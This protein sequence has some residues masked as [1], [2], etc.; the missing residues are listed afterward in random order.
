MVD[1]KNF[2]CE[3]CEKIKIRFAGPQCRKAQFAHIAYHIEWCLPVFPGKEAAVPISKLSKKST[4]IRGASVRWMSVLILLL[5]G[6][7]AAGRVGAEEKMPPLSGACEI[8]YPPFS[9][10]DEDGR[11]T[12]FSV[13]LLNAALAAMNR[14]ATYRTGPW[15]RVRG[16]LE[17]GE[18]EVLPLVGRTPEREELFDFTVPYMTMHGAIVVRDDV[19]GI[20]RLEDLR[21]RRVAVMKGDN[22]EE[23][24]RRE[25]RGIEIHTTPTFTEALQG[26]SRGEYDAVVVLRLVGLLLIREAGL[27][28]LRIIDRP[29]PDFRQ[30]FCFAV[31]DGDRKNLALLNEGLAIVMAD[32]TYRHLH[33][34]WFADLELPAN[35]KIVVG[36]DYA[37]PPFEFIDGNG[38][39]A[40]Y[41]VDL[42]RAIAREMGLDVE[43]R[44]EPWV[45]VIKGL[46]DGD[47][48]IIQGIFYTPER[49]LIYD[50]SQPHS[51]N[52]YVSIVRS[53]E[54]QPPMSFEELRGKRVIVQR[55]D[56]I[57]GMLLARELRAQITAAESQEEVL[58]ELAEGRHDC[59]LAT[60]ISALDFIA[61]HG[62]KNLTMSR[63]P[64]VS[65]DYCFAVLNGRKALLAKFNEGLAVLNE[66][67]E[68]RRI[69]D[70]WLGVYR[71][72]PPTLLVALRYSLNVLVPLLVVLLL[73]FVWSWSLRRRV[74]LSTQELR[75]SMERFRYIFEAANVGKSLTLPDGT[76]S[77]N[78]ALEEFLGYGPHQAQ[79]KRWQDVT[80]PEDIAAV[81]GELAPLLAGEKDAARFE[82][83][84]VRK[85]GRIV[86]SDVSTRLRRDDEGQPLYFVTTVVDINERKRTEEALRESEAR[87]RMLAESAPVG[88]VISDSR[89]RAV[90]ISRTFTGLFGYTIEDVPCI[91]EWWPRA[92]PDPE[93]RRIAQAKWFEAMHR[94]QDP[95]YEGVPL[96]FSITCKDGTLKHVEVRLKR[97]GDLNFILVTDVTERRKL[98]DQL[99]Q[100]QK[101]EAVGRLAGGVAHDYNNMLSVIIGFTEIALSRV[102]REEKLHFYL[103][104]ILKAANRS[105]EI[106]RQLLAF[107]RKQTISPKVL[108]VNRTIEGML[109]ILRRLIGEDIELAWLPDEQL[110]NLKMDPSQIDQLLVNLCVNA[111]DAIGGC[112]RITIE[113]NN[114][115][116]DETYCAVHEEFNPGS[117]VMLAIS[118][119]GCGMDK[120]TIANIFEPFFTTKGKHEGTGL[121]LATVYGIVKQNNGFINVYSEPG[122]G[123]TFKIYLPRFTGAE[124]AEDV[125]PL[126]MPVSGKGETILLVEDERPL[127]G[128]F[129][130]MLTM[131]GY[132]VLATESAQEALRIAGEQKQE[133]SLLITDVVM[134]EMTGRELAARLHSSLPRLKVLY[135]SGY[136]ANVI[137]HRGVLD[138]GVDFIQKPLSLTSLAAKVRAV[139]G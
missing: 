90:H 100:S 17:R 139:L 99:R 51:V 33:A 37:Y 118:D 56:A 28:N 72:S 57:H 29:I 110:W 15:D 67:G 59:A 87:F 103:E 14:E 68:Y 42:V 47:I 77:P 46:G 31:K 55:G 35:R 2:I 38:R 96:D 86:W 124:A 70:K 23:F 16:W 36:G 113:T 98:E 24:L 109:K 12:G 69:Y 138:D 71:E 10:V 81:E 53:G 9:I 75:E 5:A 3:N 25:E 21:G 6:L 112:G 120:Q 93:T 45:Q 65:L 101:L 116:F 58:R 132:N 84:Y 135:M 39:P 88:I 106:T 64:F 62:W 40:G 119:D 133:I 61:S 74:A 95:D 80:P 122:A 83:R 22:T 131:Q 115:D 89:E 79:G 78:R 92:Y 26:L 104:E 111:R 114:V 123:T 50:F 4:G 136:T 19:Q 52:H 7:Y 20:N 108:D 30:D 18:I 44:L 130:E 105:A 49:D 117:F 129:A 41:N 54:G 82:K 91:E 43:F 125:L 126:N 107:A 128:M 1:G 27:R 73:A 134:P 94:S 8:D 121:G 11:T 137:A 13:E 127:L 85:D 34:K 76:M 60:R 48:D 63:E 97:T 102:G 66:S 32:G